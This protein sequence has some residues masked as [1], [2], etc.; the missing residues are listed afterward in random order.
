MK[1]LLYK[2]F[3][4]AMH[5]VCYVFTLLFPLMV[6]IPNYP[7][8][9]GTL[10]IVPMFS[11]LF[12]GANKGKQSNDLFYSALLPI[13]KSDIVKARMLTVIIVEAVTLLLVAAFYPLKLLIMQSANIPSPFAL[14]GIVSNFAF[15]V[16]GYLIVNA[17]FF[18]MF[19]KKGRSVLAPTLISTFTY[20]IY[21][22]VFTT[23]LSAVDPTSGA[24]L[25]PGFYQAFINIELWLQF[26][27]LA[28][29]C[30]IFAGG[31]FFIFKKASQELNNADL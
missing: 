18:L 19:Y 17:I 11:V 1:S 20:V 16:V 3:R 26:V 28:I 7:L 4:L 12:L 23:V 30:L 24:P 2:E 13:R 22:M 21:I 27:Y 5:P 25:I 8:F 9:V 10:Y 6:L 29:A 15:V 31:M 14:D